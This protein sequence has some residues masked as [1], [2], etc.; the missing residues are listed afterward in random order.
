MRTLCVCVPTPARQSIGEAMT[1][2]IRLPAL[3][4][5]A[6][7]HVLRTPAAA[8]D[9]NATTSAEV[10]EL[11]ERPPR[12]PVPA[13]PQE[14]LVPPRSTAPHF[15]DGSV[16]RIGITRGI[17]NVAERVSPRRQEANCLT[18]PSGGPAQSLQ[19]RGPM[20]VFPLPRR[21]VHVRGSAEATCA[22]AMDRCASS[23]L[24]SRRRST[25]IA[26]AASMSVAT[27]HHGQNAPMREVTRKPLQAATS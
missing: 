21:A 7:G 19:I 13:A 12:D 10:E 20:P 6:D 26:A 4:R 15:P 23:N 22:P 9:M 5:D 11:I 17:K 14:C 24:L 8:E 2:K 16:T 27:H 3:A 18:F 1:S 25:T